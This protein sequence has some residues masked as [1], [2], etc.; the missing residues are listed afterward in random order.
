[1]SSST[2]PKIN[3]QRGSNPRD[4]SQWGSKA[5][6]VCRFQPGYVQSATEGVE[7]GTAWL[8]GAQACL[9]ILQILL[10]GLDRQ[11]EQ[12]KKKASFYWHSLSSLCP[13]DDSA[14]STSALDKGKCRARTRVTMDSLPLEPIFRLTHVCTFGQIGARQCFPKQCGPSAQI[15]KE[16]KGFTADI[17]RVPGTLFLHS[18]SV[19]GVKSFRVYDNLAGI[20]HFAQFSQIASLSFSTIARIFGHRHNPAMG[21]IQAQKPQLFTQFC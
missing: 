15:D 3:A 9:G 20:F 14:A 13:A 19:F 17:L 2:W 6:P 5:N 11:G 21:K 8:S 12:R 1:M 7:G 4:I 10:F 18:C 16:Q